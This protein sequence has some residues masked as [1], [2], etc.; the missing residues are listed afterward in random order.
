MIAPVHTVAPPN[1]ARSELRIAAEGFEAIMLRQM[2]AAARASDMGDDLF[3]GSAGQDTFAEMQDA[4]FADLAAGSG[5]LGLADM[6]E[7]QL[8]RPKFARPGAAQEL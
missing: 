8:A 2:L 4:Q 7:A 6:L 5:M 3:G 1:A